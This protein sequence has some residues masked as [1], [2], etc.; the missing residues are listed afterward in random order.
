M[1]SASC[2]IT[3]LSQLYLVFVWCPLSDSNR[4]PT[5]YKSVALPNELKGRLFL[6]LRGVGTI[7]TNSLLLSNGLSAITFLSVC[8]RSSTR[9]YCVGLGRH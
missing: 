8:C 7:V 4:P 3:V 5:D 1:S 2:L 9:E 6:K